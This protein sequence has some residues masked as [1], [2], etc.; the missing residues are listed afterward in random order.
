MP[1]ERLLWLAWFA[2]VMV[3]LPGCGGD[4]AGQA[5]GVNRND[6]A[7]E[8][9]D[10][11]AAPILQMREAMEARDWQ[12]ADRFTRKALIAAPDDPDVVTDVA[13]VAALNDR[14]GEAAELLVQAAELANYQPETR[15]DF[16]VRALIEVGELY[17]AIDLL[18]KTLDAQPQLLQQRR[19]LIGFL[20]EAERSELVAP[21]LHY[22]IK[23]RAFDTTLL[24]AVT[25][26]S[27]RRYSLRT[28][29]MLLERN[30]DDHRVRLGEAH[31]QL[32][33]HD[34]VAC[35]KTLREILERHPKFAPAYAMLGQAI[36]E[37]YRLE[38]VASW[39]RAAP[40]GS[41][42]RPD[43]WLTIGD[44]AMANG[45]FD[46]SAKAYW[47]AA[48]CDVNDSRCWIRLSKAIQRARTDKDSKWAAQISEEQLT[49]INRRVEQ[50]LKLR[51]AYYDFTWEGNDSQSDAV[52]VADVLFNLGR[53]WEAEAWTAI[54]ATMT[55]EPSSGLDSL[56][57]KI[58][59]R[60]K[61]DPSWISKV[62]QPALELDLS[63]WPSPKVIADQQSTFANLVPRLPSH[64]HLVLRQESQSWGLAHVAEMSNPDDP[65]LA[66]LIRS[67]GVG[68]GTLDYDLDGWPDLLVMGAGG[69]ILAENSHPNELLRN[70]GDQFERLGEIAGV[71]DRGFGQGVGIGDFNEDG[72]PDLFFANLG[73]NRLLRN[74]GDGT[75]TDCTSL[76]R[77]NDAQ[78]WSTC[79]V[80]VDMNLDGITDLLTTNYCRTV[81]GLDQPCPDPQGKPGPCHPL[82]FP[83]QGDQFFAGSPA[84]DLND[85]SPLWIGDT[86]SGRGLGLVA[87]RLDGQHQC[88][89]VANDMTPNAHY[90]FVGD[91]RVPV[92]ENAS[93]SGL[94]V[95]ARTI[96]Q[97]SM[98]IATSD[99]D[100]DG[101]LDFYVTGFAREYNILYDQVASGLWHDI[102][103]R[104]NLVTPTLSLVGFGTE[105]VD[106][107]NDGIDE[108]I[109]TN[110]HIGEFHN[111][112]SL[113]YAQEMQVFRRGGRG[114]FELVS[115]DRW[116]DYFVDPHVGKALWTADV[117]RDGKRDILVT[118]AEES[119][120]L[121][122]NHTDSSN[123]RIAFR[124]VGTT[125]SRDAIGSMI[126]FRADGRRR[127]LW[128]LA[129]GGYLCSEDPVIHAGIGS[130]S[131]ITDAVVT[132][133]DGT[134]QTLGTL[135]A[136][137]E[138]LV[139]QN[140]G[141]AFVLDSSPQSP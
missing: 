18:T 105:A 25:E 86:S 88:A 31:E 104:V 48:R 95:D 58:L 122:I 124:L 67:T 108:L 93:V 9:G 47:Q 13:K 45:A 14:K 71:G 26:T 131:Q 36:M 30:P 52:A 35:E 125:D 129:G 24:S 79:G 61:L 83:A 22:L 77:D 3:L 81:S 132:W 84:G 115:D 112:D 7:Q 127:T 107:D 60:L 99:L 103:S 54:A 113:P 50:L 114:S 56:R 16:A 72:F 130:A 63:R 128:S 34:A 94:A 49:G 12:V 69:S 78:Q 4:R 133:P 68:G 141:D 126:R 73:K 80:F 10:N 110:G 5:D 29:K 51:A 28:T 55:K 136:N 37:Q 32:D 123:N 74:N 138:Y 41:D 101:D 23:A 46:E 82:K 121:L 75:Y 43:Y 76:L 91:D 137:Q 19:N 134:N 20:G 87:G 53:T 85:V 15:V 98:G 111:P 1:I 11:A 140:Q 38:D 33:N 65:K 116:G 39:L 59:A 6:A 89:M 139:I 92:S 21:H 120:C 97:A 27:S 62:G 17:N 100:G 135:A 40:P 106:F 119:L 90:R 109:V 66:P 42:E 2:I 64:D 117:N 96:A 118:H 70:L 102:T 57:L 8:T 44:W